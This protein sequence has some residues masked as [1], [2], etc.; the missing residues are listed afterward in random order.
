[1]FIIKNPK[2]CF[3][4]KDLFGVL[5]SNQGD[6]KLLVVSRLIEVYQFGIRLFLM[7]VFLASF[8]R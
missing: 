3:E 6:P 5:Y 7:T 1:M 8:L 4:Y 2:R